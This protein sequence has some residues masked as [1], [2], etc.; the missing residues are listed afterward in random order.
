[1][2]SCSSIGSWSVSKEA[3]A[4]CGEE[5]ISETSRSLKE[6]RQTQGRRDRVCWSSDGEKLSSHVR[7]Q[8]GVATQAALIAM[9]SLHWSLCLLCWP[10]PPRRGRGWQESSD[11]L[12]LCLVLLGGF[13]PLQGLAVT[14][15]NNSEAVCWVFSCVILDAHLCGPLHDVVTHGQRCIWRLVGAHFSYFLFILGVHLGGSL[16]FL[17]INS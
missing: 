5:G 9:E 16:P 6:K 1:M 8:N 13:H 15:R 12:W 4:N 14:G 17:Q 11:S 10:Q 3:I 7:S 2:L